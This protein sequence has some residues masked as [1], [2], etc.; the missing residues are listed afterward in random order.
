MALGHSHPS[1]RLC[2][3]GQTPPLSVSIPALACATQDPEKRPPA[4]DILR[5]LEAVAAACTDKQK[6]YLNSSHPGLGIE[7][8]RL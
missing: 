6:A 3:G 7:D 2:P 4:A 1:P 5:R 8:F